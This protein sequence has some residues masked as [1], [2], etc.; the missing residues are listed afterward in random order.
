MDTEERLKAAMMAYSKAIEAV[1]VLVAGMG[2]HDH[3]EWS[4]QHGAGCQTCIG[5]RDA[6]ERAA[7]LIRV[8]ADL[9]RW[10]EPF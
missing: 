6:R 7:Q 1:N 8:S 10:G 2:G 5:Q 3:C 9:L 4:M